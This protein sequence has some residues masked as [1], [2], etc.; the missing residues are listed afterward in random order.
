MAGSFHDQVLALAGIFQSACLV[1]QLAREG[2]TDSAA[3]RAS[4]Q[5]ILALDAPD[6]ETIYGGARGVHLGLELLHTKLTGKTKS[7][8][9]EM[10]RYV[11]ALVQLENSLRRRPT[12]LDDIRQGIDT[13]RA[14]M[15][16]FESD[17][18][19]DG[20]HPLLMEK[21]AQLYSQT[22]ST[23][24]PR[25][26][27]SGEHGHLSNPAIAAKVRAALLAGIRSAVLWRQLGGRR[28]QLLFS[29]GKIA[30]TAAELLEA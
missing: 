21:L 3:L 25:I 27:V 26:M 29:R 19:T 13:A 30:R 28:W 4:I 1:Q 20:V 9:M 11:V 7:A 24:T 2:H 10:A 23:L 8:D 22:I 15:K 18:P 16:F 6:V 14:Q 5:S 17:A 12:M